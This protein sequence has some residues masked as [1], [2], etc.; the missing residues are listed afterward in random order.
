[1][2]QD[3]KSEPNIQIAKK[4]KLIFFQMSKKLRLISIQINKK[5]RLI[6]P[7]I[8]P[9][10]QE[11]ETMSFFSSIDCISTPVKS[12]FIRTVH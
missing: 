5:L 3:I 12:E 11:I 2:K 4:L 10:E 8:Y 9:N 7:N 6:K 1:M